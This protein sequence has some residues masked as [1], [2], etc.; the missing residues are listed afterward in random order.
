MLVFVVVDMDCFVCFYVVCWKKQ[1]VLLI[2]YLQGVDV[3]FFIV[4]WLLMVL[5]EY[6]VLVVMMGL[7]KCVDFEFYMI[8]WVLSSVF[9]LLILFEVQKLLVGLGMCIYGKEEIDINCLGLDL[10]QV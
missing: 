10:K 6:V 9:G 4:N 2:G 3:L 8:N 1:K 7:G 5:C